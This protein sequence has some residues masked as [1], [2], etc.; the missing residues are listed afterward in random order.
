MPKLFDISALPEGTSIYYIS[1]EETRMFHPKEEQNVVIAIKIRMDPCFS[2]G[3]NVVTV[4][5]IL[6]IHNVDNVLT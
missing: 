2:V 4:E 1:P 5:G 6:D 3:K